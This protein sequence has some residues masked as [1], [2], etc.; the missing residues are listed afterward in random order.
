MKLVSFQHR[1]SD[2]AAILSE[3]CILP[4]PGSMMDVI[5]NPQLL[6]SPMAPLP[7]DAV[8]LIAPIPHPDQDIICM[9]M[10]YTEHAEEAFGYP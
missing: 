4:L 1:D 2:Q 10:N 7:L 6:S 9:G 3:N 5:L 8:E